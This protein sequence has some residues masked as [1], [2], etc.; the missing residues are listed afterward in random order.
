MPLALQKQAL[1]SIQGKYAVFGGAVLHT[2]AYAAG[3]APRANIIANCITK[4]RFT[5]TSSGRVF[6]QPSLYADKQSRFFCMKKAG[7]V[8]ERGV[9]A[10]LH[11][12]KGD[13]ERAASTAHRWQRSKDCNERQHPL[14]T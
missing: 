6:H 4:K 13:C 7:I 14:M 10:Q 8:G 9:L 11:N 5:H 1:E 2:V 12:R 3:I